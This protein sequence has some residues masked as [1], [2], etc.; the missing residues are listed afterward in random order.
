MPGQCPIKKAF[1]G[2]VKDS[3]KE[4]LTYATEYIP[5]KLIVD[6]K[7]PDWVWFF[8]CQILAPAAMRTWMASPVSPGVPPV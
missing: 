3:I 4:K 2:D 5:V 8:M 1:F 6:Q 7:P